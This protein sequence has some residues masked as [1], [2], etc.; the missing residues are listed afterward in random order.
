[1][2]TKRGQHAHK[3]T[4]K[5]MHPYVDSATHVCANTQRHMQTQAYVTGHGHRPMHTQAVLTSGKPCS[6]RM[7]RDAWEAAADTLRPTHTSRAPTYPLNHDAL[8][9]LS[10]YSSGKRELLISKKWSQG[11]M[12]TRTVA[13]A[14]FG[15]LSSHTG[16]FTQ[17]PASPGP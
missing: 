14:H 17:P 5:Q 15:V 8:S 4:S 10:L 16:L 13:L 9:C 11:S 3:P 12:L 1:M 7:R 6:F 2:K